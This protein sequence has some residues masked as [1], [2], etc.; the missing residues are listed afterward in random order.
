MV[1]PSGRVLRYRPGF[2]RSL[3]GVII[4]VIVTFVAKGRELG[5]STHDSGAD[6]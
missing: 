4:S 3:F 1:L 6:E 2:R 5:D